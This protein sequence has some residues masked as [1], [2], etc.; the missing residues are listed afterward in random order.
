MAALYSARSW[1]KVG[2]TEEACVD[3]VVV[4]A[5]AVIFVGAL[6][7]CVGVIV[8]AVV[9]VIV[10]VAVEVEVDVVV[11]PKRERPS[12]LVPLVLP[13]ILPSPPR[14][15]LSKLLPSVGVGVGRFCVAPPPC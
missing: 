5:V 9:G 2:G 11:Y 8:V 4:V 14:L 15:L 12:P 10:V 7:V 6:C 3:V 13:P 1:S